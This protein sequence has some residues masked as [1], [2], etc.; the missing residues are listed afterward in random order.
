MEMVVTGDRLGQR[1][2]PSQRAAD[3]SLQMLAAEPGRDQLCLHSPQWA[4]R[5]VPLPLV[6]SLAIP[7]ALGVTDKED[8]RG[9]AD[10]LPEGQSAD[11]GGRRVKPLPPG[12]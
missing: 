10:L 5:D 1:A 7:G 2:R 12:F 8:C 3:D 9:H 11:P 6:D 4:E